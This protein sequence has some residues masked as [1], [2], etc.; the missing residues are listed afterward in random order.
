MVKQHETNQ[1]DRR[2]RLAPSHSL[3]KR[4]TNNPI[5]DDVIAHLASAYEN[6]RARQVS[7][8][9]RMRRQTLRPAV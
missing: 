8:W 6:A 1:S 4:P 2:E 9:E 5:A 7:E 3:Q